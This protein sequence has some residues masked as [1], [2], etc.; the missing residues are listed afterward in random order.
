[1]HRVPMPLGERCRDER[2]HRQAGRKIHGAP[3]VPAQFEASSRLPMGLETA[4]P[5]K[6]VFEIGKAASCLRIDPPAPA[7]YPEGAF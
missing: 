5:L 3:Q 4:S 7:N 2:I 1:M 6:P